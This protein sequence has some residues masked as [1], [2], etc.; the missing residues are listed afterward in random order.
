MPPGPR[1]APRL[2]PLGREQRRFVRK[3]AQPGAHVHTDS[4]HAQ[5]AD[6]LARVIGPCPPAGDRAAHQAR[7][8]APPE[9]RASR[10]ARSS[11]PLRDEFEASAPPAAWRP[12]CHGIAVVRVR[13]D[14]ALAGR[15]QRSSRSRGPKGPLAIVSGSVGHV[16]E[17]PARTYRSSSGLSLLM[18]GRGSDRAA[19]GLHRRWVRGSPTSRGAAAVCLGHV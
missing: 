1:R 8:P 9:M 15:P 16:R 14:A 7:T 3:R 13:P 18:H 5:P 19:A 2:R 10:L 12:H 4:H 17:C 6:H 11:H